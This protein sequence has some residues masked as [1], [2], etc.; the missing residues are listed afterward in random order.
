MEDRNENSAW[1]SPPKKDDPAAGGRPGGKPIGKTSVPDWITG[2]N[3]SS[4]EMAGQ[5]A[6]STQIFRAIGSL[7][8]VLRRMDYRAG[9]AYPRYLWEEEISSGGID[10]TRRQ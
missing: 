1:D 3:R 8:V 4:S 9:A 2:N 5:Y 6:P 10:T 7:K